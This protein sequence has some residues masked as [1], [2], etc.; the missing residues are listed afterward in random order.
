MTTN[1]KTRKLSVKKIMETTKM[2]NK[3]LKKKQQRR[4]RVTKIYWL[5]LLAECQTLSVSL[6][7]A[8]NSSST[9]IRR[10]SRSIGTRAKDEHISPSSSPSY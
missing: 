9:A 10:K 8:A 3:K 5:A 6:F 4:I 2:S 1:E 7:A